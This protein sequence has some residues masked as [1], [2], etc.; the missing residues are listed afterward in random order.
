MENREFYD[1]FNQKIKDLDLKQMKDI[2]NN[3]IRK[4]PVSKYE[5]VL[6]MFNDDNEVDTIA[7][8]K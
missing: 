6:N 3:I 5:E 2:M 8:E 7:I 1:K 4:V